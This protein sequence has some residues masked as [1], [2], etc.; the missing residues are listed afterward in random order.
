[1]HTAAT[2]NPTSR[3]LWRR[4]AFG[5]LIAMAAGAQA[6]PGDPTDPPAR[7]ARVATV[8]G[9]AWVYD[10][11]GHEW[12]QLLRN[13]TVAQ[14]DH[15]R[16]DDGARLVLRIG[17]TSVYVGGRAE[18]GLPRLDEGAVSIE[19]ARGDLGMRLRAGVD[20]G[21]LRVITQQGQAIPER[22]GVYR[23]A[24][25]DRGSLLR[26]LRG[27]MRFES[28]RDGGPTWVDAGEQLEVWWAD[29]GQRAERQPLRSDSFGDFVL[30][31]SRQDGEFDSPS[32]AQGYVSPE[33]T[34]AEDLDRYGNWQVSPDYGPVWFPAVAAVDWAPY[35]YG[36]WVWTRM[37]GWTWVDDAP[38]GFAPFHYGRWVQWGGRWCWAPGTYV[39][40]PVYAPALVAWGGG[41]SVS[42]GV[43]IS[44]GFDRRSPPP[45]TGWVPL[46]PRQA[47]VPSYRHSDIYVQRV[48]G[49]GNP[50]GNGMNGPAAAP[51][52]PIG[53]PRPPQRDDRW[54]GQRGDPRDGRDDA[55][56]DAAFNRG[57]PAQTVMPQQAPAA[58]PA[59]PQ[60]QEA[61]PQRQEDWAQRRDEIGR[62]RFNNDERRERPQPQ[63]QPQ[64]QQPAQPQFQPQQFQQAQPRPQAPAAQ[65]QAQPQQ[66]QPQQNRTA[67][68]ERGDDRKRDRD[69]RKKE[70][71]R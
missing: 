56:N 65:P 57:R 29:G 70:N 34:G 44:L 16:T 50:R 59:P 49:G 11:E 61:Q 20:V 18:L 25:L 26:A 66:Q 39:R 12:V 41:P 68:V 67:P 64:Q 27:R 46:A 4:L 47:F 5:L 62:D 13:Q 43:S 33:M 2:P 3:A 9:T 55:R 32:F 71:D 21:D 14:G 19:L 54:N 23:V 36:H 17:P 8:V 6:Q 48:N 51:P 38:W 31:Q 52:Q 53:Q 15:V 10:E 69:D 37:W 24:Q 28:Y 30:D 42:V 7:V 63:P 58:V 60:R 35:R 1:M 22:D 40:H 45:R